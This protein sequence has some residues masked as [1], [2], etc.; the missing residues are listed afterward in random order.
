MGFNIVISKANNPIVTD[1]T[2][3]HGD[4]LRQIFTCAGWRNH[5]GALAAHRT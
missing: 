3:D 1:I 5:E 4:K 2:A